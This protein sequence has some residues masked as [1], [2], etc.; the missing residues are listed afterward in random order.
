MLTAERTSG[1]LP[2]CMKAKPDKILNCI[3]VPIYLE[4]TVTEVPVLGVVFA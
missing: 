4:I 1:R 2:L 3:Y